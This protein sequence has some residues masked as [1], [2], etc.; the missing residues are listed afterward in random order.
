M[1][2]ADSLSPFAQKC[3]TGRGDKSAARFVSTGSF[4][5]RTARGT[6]GMIRNQPNKRRST[7]EIRTS[8]GGDARPPIATVLTACGK[9][10]EQWVDDFCSYIDGTLCS[11]PSIGMRRTASVPFPQRCLGLHPTAEL[12]QSRWSSCPLPAL[13]G[14]GQRPA[15]GSVVCHDSRYRPRVSGG[16]LFRHRPVHCW[17]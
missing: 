5:S 13:A 1:W 8:G 11:A 6:V 17:R 2:R 16:R 3:A 14:R 4:T 15:V 7:I 10:S 9:T 12:Q